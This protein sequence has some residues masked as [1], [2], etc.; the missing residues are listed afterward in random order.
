VTQLS[1]CESCRAREAT[2]STLIISQKQIGG[3]DMGEIISQAEQLI[4]SNMRVENLI[5][6]HGTGAESSIQIYHQHE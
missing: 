4:R 1:I 2:S 5:N 6:R 3:V